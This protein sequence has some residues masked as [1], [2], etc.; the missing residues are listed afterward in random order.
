MNDGKTLYLVRHAKSGWIDSSQLDF[1]RILAG[2]GN[3]DA[4]AMGRHLQEN[5]IQPD[6]VICSPAWRA[7]Q[8]LE[9]L[10]A[11]MN[12]PIA[13][14]LYNKSIYEAATSTLLEIVRNI[15]DAFGS[16]MLIGHN[17]SMS[18]LINHLTG[19]PISNMPTCSIATIRT[20]SNH[21]KKTDSA[22]SQLLD[23]TY[24]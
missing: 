21:W 11:G 1:D 19:E 8:T 14:V 12:V 13:D 23:F 20:P 10:A 6:I 24:P 15:D 3:Q 4:A 9:H 5:G 16:A 17:P 7:V 22:A 2:Q 18:G